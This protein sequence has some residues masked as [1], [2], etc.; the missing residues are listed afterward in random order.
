MTLES[1]IFGL[2][3]NFKLDLEEV[4]RYFVS[5][6]LKEECLLQVILLCKDFNLLCSLREVKMRGLLEWKNFF[7]LVCSVG[8]S[9]AGCSN[10]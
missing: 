5:Q 10:I 1:N 2:G 4:L 6:N 9:E 3:E 7:R 8:E